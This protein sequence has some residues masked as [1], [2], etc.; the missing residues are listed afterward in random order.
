MKGQENSS[1]PLPIHEFANA[2]K[3]ESPLPI[4][5]FVNACKAREA[6]IQYLVRDEASR[7]TIFQLINSLYQENNSR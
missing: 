4:H 2:C 1:C 3:G 5:A 7:K 6:K